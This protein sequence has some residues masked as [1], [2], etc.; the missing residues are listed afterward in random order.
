MLILH[1]V[2]RHV[3]SFI[4]LNSAVQI[5]VA[6]FDTPQFE[7]HALVYSCCTN[8]ASSKE[9]ADRM[10]MKGFMHESEQVRCSWEML[11]ASRYTTEE[12][13]NNSGSSPSAFLY[14]DIMNEISLYPTHESV[15]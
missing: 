7:T 10:K 3:N 9:E 5:F 1:R 4:V 11:K 2:L 14:F 13:N 12:Q 15:E 6:F 8:H